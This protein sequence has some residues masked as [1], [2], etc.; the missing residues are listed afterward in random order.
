[1]ER[2]NEVV[3]ALI[4]TALGGRTIRDVEAE[5]PPEQL[6]LARAM[7]RV[8]PAEVVYAVVQLAGAMGL[9]NVIAGGDVDASWQLVCDTLNESIRQHIEVFEPQWRDMA[10][11]AAF[12]RQG[13]DE[14][15][16]LDQP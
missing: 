10:D 7:L 13:M 12:I 14:I 6:A 9:D 15:E 3:D 4:E 11:K 16:Q 2:H 8:K 1:M 5:V